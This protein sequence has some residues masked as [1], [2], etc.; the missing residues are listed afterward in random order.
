[1]RERK[2]YASRLLRR[3]RYQFKLRRYCTDIFFLPYYN[4]LLFLVFSKEIN[5]KYQITIIEYSNLKISVKTYQQNYMVYYFT[6]LGEKK[7]GKLIIIFDLDF[8][9]FGG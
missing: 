5:K 2:L 9:R 3:I 6:Q 7:K 4:F 8:F 1:M